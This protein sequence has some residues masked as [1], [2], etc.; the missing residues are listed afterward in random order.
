MF[1]GPCGSLLELQLM[2][3]K[4]ELLVNGH[5]VESYTAGKRQSQGDSLRD[6]RSRPDGSY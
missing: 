1:T 6:L 5:I 2:N 3:G 4:W